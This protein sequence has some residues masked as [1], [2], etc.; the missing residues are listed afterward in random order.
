MPDATPEQIVA[1]M[2][3][4]TKTDIVERLRGRLPYEEYS[5]DIAQEAAD[6]IEQLLQACALCVR[7]RDELAAEIERLRAYAN[8]ERSL[9]AEGPMIE[10]TQAQQEIKRLRAALQDIAEDPYAVDGGAA[11]IGRRALEPKP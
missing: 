4:R 5:W 1:F 10:L 2:T 9:G 8:H 6:E 7:A 3:G 11:E